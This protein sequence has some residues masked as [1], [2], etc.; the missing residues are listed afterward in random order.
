MEKI[1][2][3]LELMQKNIENGYKSEHAFSTLIEDYIHDNFWQINEENEDVATYLNDDV[4]DICE[5]TE[6]GLEGTQ[7]RK[8]I[9]DAYYKLL[10]MVKRVNDANAHQ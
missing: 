7:F 8:Q 6:P 10:E 4:L 3:L 2:S 1:R 5:Q 9:S